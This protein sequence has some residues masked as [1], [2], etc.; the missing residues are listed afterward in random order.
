MPYLFPTLKLFGSFYIWCIHLITHCSP[1]GPNGETVCLVCICV[2]TKWV[3]AIPLTSKELV[4]MAEAFHLHIMA[5]YGP[6]VAVHCDQGREFE[7]PFAQYLSSLGIQQIFAAVY[8]PQANGMVE[9]YSGMLHSG[10]RKL[11]VDCK[12]ANWV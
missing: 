3:E 8:H 2:L 5:W 12:E 7:G 11:L 10:I 6:P 1:P 9:W 4:V